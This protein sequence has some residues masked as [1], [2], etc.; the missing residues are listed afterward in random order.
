MEYLI[1]ALCAWW[2]V[3]FI[4]E[5]THICGVLEFP[6]L[7]TQIVLTI[8][9]FPFVAIYRIFFRHTI[10]PVTYE[11]VT[12]A[13]I[14]KDSKHLFDDLYICFDKDAKKFWN[15]VFLFRVKPVV[16]NN[17]PSSPEGEFRFGEE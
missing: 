5:E 1:G 7:V 10:R 2:V 17:T 9:S 12:K 8:I 4:E 11:Q 14:M 3:S 13:N 6:M 15:K 16:F